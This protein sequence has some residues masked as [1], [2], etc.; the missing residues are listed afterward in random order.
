MNNESYTVIY[1]GGFELPNKNAAAQRVLG[2]AKAI[3]DIG[4]NVVLVGISNDIS[5]DVVLNTKKDIQ[6]FDCYEVPYPKGTKSWVDYLIN[7]RH[8]IDVINKYNDTRCVILYN[9]QSVSMHRIIQYCHKR[10]IKCIAD[11]TE[12]YQAGGSFI[13]KQLKNWDTS[14]RM[15]R[16]HFECDGLIVISR[17]LENYYSERVSLINIPPLVDIA[18]EKWKTACNQT[19][20][21]VFSYV[22][23]PSDR[24]ERL[25]LII[26]SIEQLSLDEN[27][28]AIPLLCIAGITQKEYEEMYQTVSNTERV[29]FVGRVP[30]QEAL[31]IVGGSKWAIVIRNRTRVVE[32]G[33][34]TKVVESLAC[35]VPVIANKFSNIED[36]LNEDNSILLENQSGLTEAIS[37]AF[38]QSNSRVVDKTVFDY[39][40]YIKTIEQFFEKVIQG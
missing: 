21:Y 17:Y 23:K 5:F 40:N 1:M 19:K 26:Q 4:L 10:G 38:N 27:E 28:K 22:G 16:V 9:F 35:G 13:H 32:A 30:H 7:P 20:K 12:W 29:S 34:P 3:R 24:K 6:G 11:V 33:F 25:D 36:Y 15:N 2:N 31:D 37:E 8:Y 39:R 14:Y 18:E